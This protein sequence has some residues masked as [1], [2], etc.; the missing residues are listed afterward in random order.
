M[1]LKME[2]TQT[3]DGPW[4]FVDL[5][6]MPTS[7]KQMMLELATT[8]LARIKKRTVGQ[9]KGPLGKLKGYSTNPLW[10]PLKG[11]RVVPRGGKT[12]KE[13]DA[14]YFPGGY[15]EFKRKFSGNSKVNYTL[16]GATMAQAVVLKYDSSRSVIGFSGGNAKK[17]AKFLQQRSVFFGLNAK[18]AKVLA[19][20]AWKHI[21]RLMRGQS[22]KSGRGFRARGSGAG[23]RRRSKFKF[24]KRIT[25]RGLALGVR[26]GGRNLRQRG[27]ARQ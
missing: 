22:T 18:D 9:G 17:I 19:K 16:T 23:R 21:K 13:G 11:G 10:Y 7:D 27:R 6:S 20:L 2:I 1:K 26:G 15:K 25:P 4:G 3:G 8:A 14:M 5:S 24:G 12:T